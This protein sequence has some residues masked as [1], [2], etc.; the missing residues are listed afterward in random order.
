MVMYSGSINLVISDQNC[1]IRIVNSEN[2]LETDLESG[3]DL[4]IDLIDQIESVEMRSIRTKRSK[5]RR[6]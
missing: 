2:N 6:S 4:E 1:V 3:I 5:V